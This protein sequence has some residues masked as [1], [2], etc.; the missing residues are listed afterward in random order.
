MDSTSDPGHA[1]VEEN[2]G[3]FK[4][5]FQLPTNRLDDTL[6][7]DSPS[8]IHNNENGVS[9]YPPPLHNRRRFGL[10][11][12]SGRYFPGGAQAYNPYDYESKYPEDPHGTETGTNARV[13]WTYLDVAEEYDLERVESWK[14]TIDVLMI[15]VRVIPNFTGSTDGA[16]SGRSLFCY[17]DS[18]CHPSLAKFATRLRPTFKQPPCRARQHPASYSHWHIHFKYT[19]GI[20]ESSI[21]A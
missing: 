9:S 16:F 4:Q 6:Q 21:N 3:E 20:P 8:S 10:L 5:M 11:K 17:R 15:F 1:S 2:R 14:D 19:I 12:H 7:A 13:W 18:V